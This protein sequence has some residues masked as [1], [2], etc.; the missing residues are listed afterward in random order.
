MKIDFEELPEYQKNLKR[1]LKK[2]KTLNRDLD[3]VRKTLNKELG[4]SL[5]FSFRMENLRITTCVRPYGMGR[6]VREQ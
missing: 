1:L 6:R 2:H 4:A 5:A 3:D